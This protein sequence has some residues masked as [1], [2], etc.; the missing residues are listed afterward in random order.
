MRRAAALGGEHAFVR[1]S[2]V[3]AE[4]LC[5][6]RLSVCVARIFLENRTLSP[7]SD[8]FCLLLA[9]FFGHFG[10]IHYQEV[11]RNSGVLK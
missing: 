5:R 3:I 8:N 4:D 7:V 6:I 10:I 9:A 11:G 2:R 1:P